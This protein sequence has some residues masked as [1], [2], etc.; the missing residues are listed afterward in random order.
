MLNLED[1]YEY[2]MKKLLCY[3]M[4]VQEAYYQ[5]YDFNR[6][7]IGL[8]EKSFGE[9]E[10]LRSYGLFLKFVKQNQLEM[11]IQGTMYEEFYQRCISYLYRYYQ[12]NSEVSNLEQLVSV[13]AQENR[14]GYFILREK[15]EIA[16][17]KNDLIINV[18]IGHDVSN[19]ESFPKKKTLK[20]VGNPS[21][22]HLLS[23]ANLLK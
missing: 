14:Q 17:F 1:L 4:E 5:S 8:Y 10:M 2:C 23:T 9:T 19:D 15:K 11:M 16:F 3:K 20:K 21:N 22:P 18:P 7:P 12:E 6:H 13:L